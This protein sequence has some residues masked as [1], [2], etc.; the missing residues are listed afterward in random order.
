MKI[1]RW[2][3]ERLAGYEFQCP[4]WVQEALEAELAFAYCM[5][6][7]ET[8]QVV[9]WLAAYPEGQRVEILESWEN[10][11]FQSQRPLERLYV[12]LQQFCREHQIPV[13]EAER[14]GSV[15]K[16]MDEALERAGFVKEESRMLRKLSIQKSEDAGKDY[17]W[18]TLDGLT[19]PERASLVKLLEKSGE[20]MPEYRGSIIPELT[21][22]ALRQGQAEAYLFISH[23]PGMLLMNQFVCAS[24]KAGSYLWKQA[25]GALA[26]YE[27]EGMA[28]YAEF[29]AYR[30]EIMGDAP[31]VPVDIYA[32][33][34]TDLDILSPEDTELELGIRADG[35]GDLDGLL[36]SR[37]YPLS[38]LLKEEQ[39]EHHMALDEELHPKLLVI[40]QSLGGEYLMEIRTLADDVNAGHFRF[41]ITTEFPGYSAGQK[42]MALVSRLNREL[43]EGTVYWD[44]K[45]R[46]ILRSCLPE[47]SL[48]DGAYWRRF[49]RNWTRACRLIYN[50]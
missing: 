37:L 11:A 14:S 9:A 4:A 17:E 1:I 32:W 26:D 24:E 45:G 8:G 5:L 18:K 20:D 30:K 13:A 34:D 40:A 35:S 7:E 43:P 31:E 44:E 10:P 47:K 12:R 49:Y 29:R 42:T 33:V 15:S 27:K 6:E 23:Y 3:E 2:S 38:E 28:C 22:I 46:L 41:R 39:V 50:Q 25:G 36:L 19:E 21:L 48:L 16:A